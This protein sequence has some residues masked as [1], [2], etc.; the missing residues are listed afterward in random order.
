MGSSGSGEECEEMPMASR[1]RKR[2]GRISYAEN[3]DIDADSG[4]KEEQEDFA[5][6]LR[7]RLG[8]E[9]SDRVVACMEEL[10]VDPATYFRDPAGFTAPVV[11]AGLKKFCAPWITAARARGT[12]KIDEPRFENALEP[13]VVGSFMSWMYYSSLVCDEFRTRFD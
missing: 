6:A 10:G 2:G 5:G 8:D 9:Q 1:K 7:G 12:E 3:E 4:G 11:R 13:V